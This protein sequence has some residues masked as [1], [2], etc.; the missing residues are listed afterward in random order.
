MRTDDTDQVRAKANVS[1]MLVGHPD[2][3]ALVGLWSYNGPAIL[4]AVAGRR[5]DRPGEDHRVRR[6]RRDARPASR[7][8]AIVGTVVQQPYEFGYQSITLLAKAL[9]GDRSG[10]PP[11]PPDVH[12]DD[13]DPPEQR[14]RVQDA[15]SRS[16]AA[17]GRTPPLDMAIRS[18]LRG[19][20]KRFPG[21][22]AL[23][24]VSLDVHA[25]EVVALLGENGAGKSTLMKIVGGIEQPDAGEVLI[26]GA[27]VVMR[28]VARRRR[29]SGSRSSTR[30]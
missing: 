7:S 6:R 9:K 20:D 1:E 11:A 3:A 19:I 17:A 4:N 8:G 12:P 15:S 22:H 13:G 16:C 24:G 14:G 23:R 26:D 30:S 21:V 29:R 28:D 27:P 18:Q 25:G 2:V 5:Q 10:I